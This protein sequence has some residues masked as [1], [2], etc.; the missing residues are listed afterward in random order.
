MYESGLKLFLE[1]SFEGKVSGFTK[2]SGVGLILFLDTTL[3]KAV[4]SIVNTE[5]LI[6]IISEEWVHR[7]PFRLQL[8]VYLVYPSFLPS[9]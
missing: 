3:L 6:I 2:T 5:D 8:N 9:S 7:D 4:D 1:S